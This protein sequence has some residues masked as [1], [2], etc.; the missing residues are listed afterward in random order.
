MQELLLAI[1][2]SVP[3][4]R[5]PPSPASNRFPGRHLS[6]AMGRRRDFPA[7]SVEESA[8][9]RERHGLNSEDARSATLKGGLASAGVVSVYFGEPLGTGLRFLPRRAPQDF[10]SRGIEDR[11]GAAMRPKT[12]P[13]AGSEE[14]TPAAR[15]NPRAVAIAARPSPRSA[16]PAAMAVRP[17]RRA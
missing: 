9:P 1:G 4:G 11:S 7:L 3:A 16:I 12:L 17:Q 14:V 5:H 2:P 6:I 13:T 10:N 15:E 8:S